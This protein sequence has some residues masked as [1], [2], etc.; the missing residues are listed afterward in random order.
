[1]VCDSISHHFHKPNVSLYIKI[2]NMSYKLCTKL[3]EYQKSLFWL[4]FKE[5]SKVC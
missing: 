5:K 4:N 1:M 2:N 3:N